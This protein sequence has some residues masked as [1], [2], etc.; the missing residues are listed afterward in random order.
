MKHSIIMKTAVA[1]LPFLLVPASDVVAKPKR[2]ENIELAARINVAENICDVN[3]GGKLLHH[4]MLGAA[5]L[6]VSMETAAKMADGR[7]AEIVRHLNKTR[8]LDEFC[9]NARRGKL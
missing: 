1:I 9:R 4:V 5:E 8:R 7:H 6:R 2:N 3:F